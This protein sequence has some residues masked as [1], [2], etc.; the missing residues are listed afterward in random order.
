[1][2]STTKPREIAL[3][4]GATLLLIGSV[5]AKTS[6]INIEVAKTCKKAHLVQQRVSE[7]ERR[8]GS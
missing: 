1:M 4:P 2:I 3:T 5:I 7:F 6:S 8:F